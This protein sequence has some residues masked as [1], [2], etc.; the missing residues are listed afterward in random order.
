MM[1]CLQK[2]ISR[3]NKIGAMMISCDLRHVPT[4]QLDETGVQVIKRGAGR[5][6]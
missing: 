6:L 3:R 4:S 1:G 5:I 2:T